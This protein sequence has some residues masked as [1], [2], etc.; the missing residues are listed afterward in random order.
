M[1]FNLFH[2]LPLIPPPSPRLLPFFFFF[3]SCHSDLS[4]LYA[5]SGQRGGRGEKETKD[6]R[7]EGQ[8]ETERP[9]S[10]THLTL[11]TN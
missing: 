8:G 7:L 10:Y 5:V 4:I 9:V 6:G 2:F 1:S 3:T 11:P